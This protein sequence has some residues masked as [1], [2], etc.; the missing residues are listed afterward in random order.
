MIMSSELTATCQLVHGLV[1]AALSAERQP[2]GMPPVGRPMAG[3]AAVGAYR[4]ALSAPASAS[5]LV[6]LQYCCLPVLPPSTQP[7]R[8]GWPV[9]A[10]Q[11]GLCCCSPQ[12]GRDFLPRG[13]NIVTRRPLILQLVK[14]QPASGQYA[15][16]GEFLHQQGTEFLR[17]WGQV[18]ELTEL[19]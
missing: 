5:C 18:T 13:S 1:T 15:E 19:S 8:R 14:T 2:L 9:Q 17:Y 3:C 6:G 12:V 10:G 11:T 4:V 16:W 7:Q